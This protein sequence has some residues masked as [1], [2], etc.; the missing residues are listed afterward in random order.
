MS[1]QH[2]QLLYPTYEDFTGGWFFTYTFSLRVPGLPHFLIKNDDNNRLFLDWVDD[3]TPLDIKSGSFKLCR[4][5]N[6]SSVAQLE[7]SGNF[8]PTTS[9]LRRF[10]G[11]IDLGVTYPYEFTVSMTLASPS[12]SKSVCLSYAKVETYARTFFASMRSLNPNNVCF[13]LPRNGHSIWTNEA[14]LRNSS[15][16]LAT[17]LDSGFSEATTHS[18]SAARTSVSTE[19]LVPFDFTDSDEELDEDDGNKLELAASARSEPSPPVVYKTIRITQAAYS[20][21]ASVICWIGTGYID[22]APLK[23]TSL[24]PSTSSGPESTQALPDDSNSS[25]SSSLPHP[26]SPKS[27]Y[28]LSHLLE[29]PD[30]SKLALENFKSQLTP[31]NAAY[32]LYTDVAS[33]YPELRDIALEYAVEDWEEVVKSK[34][35][36]EMRKK[37]EAGEGVDS[38]TAMLLSQKLMERWGK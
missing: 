5:S 12:P 31:Q 11:S 6:P 4:T 1:I 33:A 37:A 7:L 38:H 14:I 16:Y 17:L 13:Y 10:R 36:D 20:T 26:A 34:A 18:Q 3:S 9:E 32:E 15:Q 21:Y 8:P 25:Q 19:A 2:T 24:F 22:F 35:W 30:L 23:S 29:I 28:R 27:V